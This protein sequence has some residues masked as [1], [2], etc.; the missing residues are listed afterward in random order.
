ME[1]SALRVHVGECVPSYM[2]PSAFMQLASLPMNS[3]K[4]DRK[5]LPIPRSVGFWTG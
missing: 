4:L 5:R 1:W 2:V 3:G